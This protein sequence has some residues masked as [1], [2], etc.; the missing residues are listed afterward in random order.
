MNRQ[1]VTSPLLGAS[2]S[3]P[4]N[5]Y[6]SGAK[7]SLAHCWH[8]AKITLQSNYVNF[9][10]VMVPLGIIAGKMGW[11]S[12]AVF[13]L[14]FFAII[15]LAAI[16]SFATEEVSMKLGDTLGGLLNATFGNAVSIA[17]LKR[18]EI[19]LVQASMLG[20]ILSNLLLVMGMCF[21]L[22]GV[23]QRGESG[24][25]YEQTFSPATA[26]TTCSLMTLASASLILP[27]TL[28]AVLDQR[29]SNEKAQ[30][31]LTLSHGTAI[32]LLSLYVL[33]LVFQV[34]THS[35]LFD[36]ENQ[37]E[38]SGEVEP[39]EPTLGPIAAIA[40][41]AVTTLLI[42][43]CADYLVDSI[44][45]FVKA[46]GISRAFVGLILIPI[47]GNAAE[48]VTAVVV[49]VRDK[50][51]LAMGVAIGSSIQIALLVTP[52]LVIVGWITGYEMTL[53]FETFQTVVFAMSVL[54]VTCTVQDAKCNYLE[55]AMLI[56][57]YIIIGLAFYALPSSDGI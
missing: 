14:N 20:S 25:G 37:Y 35:N 38:G 29:S 51:D 22:G 48:H 34:R 4:T 46:S 52:F 32:I 6:C 9:L 55:G 19:A 11:G 21:L 42:T 23:M 13:T 28:Y 41:L 40:V 45:D 12:T 39:V 30:S 27:A 16:L 10:L 53:H 56:G 7:R 36:P 26:Q 18:N 2:A 54:F 15:P 3:A 49:S 24:K 57:L 47:V 5:N 31:I 17:A 43:F 44:D 1:S 33:Y 50:M 8:I